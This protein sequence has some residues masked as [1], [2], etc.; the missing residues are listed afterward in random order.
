MNIW[1]ITTGSSDVQLK[2]DE[3]WNDWHREI[4]KQYHRLDFNPQTV[5]DD[6]P[7]R[8]PPRVLG[9]AYE[10][11]PDEV[12]NQLTFPL[13]KA[14][15]FELTQTQVQID[16]IILLLT[17][18]TQVFDED[19]KHDKRCPYWQDT[20]LLQPILEYYLLEAF[21][22]ATIEPLYL[23]P[24]SKEQG[25][26]DWNQTLAL[27]QTQLAQ[28]DDVPETVYVSHQAGT[29]AISSAVQFTSLARFRDR[30]EFLV[31][32]EYR[33]HQT[34]TI[35]SSTYLSAIRIQEAK[36][37]LERYD[38]AGVRDILGL[39]QGSQVDPERKRLKYLLDASIQW[40]FAEFHRF[41]KVLV[42]RK[43]FPDLTF[44][45]WRPAYESAYLAIVRL[46]QENTVEAFF[47]SFRALEGLTSRWAEENYPREIERDAKKGL[48]LKS[49]I[50]RKLP[51]NKWFDIKG[52]EKLKSSIG[53][54][55]R[56]LFSLLREAK[57]EWRQDPHIKA[58]CAAVDKDTKNSQ[59]K[60][61]FDERNNLFHRLEGLQEEEIYQAWDTSQELWLEKVIGCLNFVTEQTFQSIEEASLMAKVHQELLDVIEQL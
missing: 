52:S 18:Q 24:E 47:H 36:A 8:L 13:L 50:C 9:L 44:P 3:L 37:L 40:N 59:G 45:W 46:A 11:F 35:S 26:D 53:L 60:N 30:V 22:Q 32:N 28:L 38:Y 19:E 51:L 23:K 41:K 5:D 6:G 7:F 48:Q 25:L 16:K 33:E 43:L 49:D 61:W 20:C 57:P 2:S 56:S 34:R 14:F 55:G 15:S 21:P 54:Y 42:D 1:L 27:V 10:A 58:V 12:W 31:S 39:T 4:R 29:P 17:D